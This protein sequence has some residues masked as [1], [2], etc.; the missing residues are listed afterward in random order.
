MNIT[1]WY[2]PYLALCGILF[3]YYFMLSKRL[4]EM[5]KKLLNK[6]PDRAVAIAPGQKKGKWLSVPSTNGDRD[7]VW[8]K[9]SECG[10]R[11]Y[12]ES[13]HDRKTKQC[14]CSRCGAVMWE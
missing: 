5:E 2:I 11:I 13:E 1:V 7:F 6:K 3:I 9:C 12:S 4:D 10:L 8:W 14:Y